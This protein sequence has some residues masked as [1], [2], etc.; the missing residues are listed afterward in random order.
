MELLRIVSI[1]MI[2]FSH[3]GHGDYLFTA[4]DWSALHIWIA[5]LSLLGK[6]GVNI[7]VLISGYY[8]V[9]EKTAHS[10]P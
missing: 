6:I 1:V 10:I 7:F 9:A 3:I 8:L 2:V 5:I 4:G